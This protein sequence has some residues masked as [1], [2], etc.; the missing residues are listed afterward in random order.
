MIAL[1]PE[2]QPLVTARR[3]AD[4]LEQSIERKSGLERKLNQRAD[5]LREI[6][7]RIAAAYER[8]A[9]KLTD[10]ANSVGASRFAEEE[11]L[12]ALEE[13]IDAGVLFEET[14]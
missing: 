3:Q 6:G 13:K 12:W 9:E 7:E 14:V 11:K 2:D 1:S 5:R 4:A 8:R 10:I